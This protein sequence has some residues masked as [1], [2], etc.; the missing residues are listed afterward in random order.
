[1]TI[2]GVVNGKLFGLNRGWG[3]VAMGDVEDH[4]ERPD[5]MDMSL[6]SIDGDIE[7]S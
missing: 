2:K 1:M 4:K 6:E 7:T 5:G 3:K